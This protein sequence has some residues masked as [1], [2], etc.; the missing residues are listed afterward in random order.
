MKWCSSPTASVHLP[1]IGHSTP[2]FNW[3]GTERLVRKH[4]ASAGIP[5]YMYPSTLLICELTVA[6]EHRHSIPC[7][8]DTPTTIARFSWHAQEYTL[9]AHH[10]GPYKLGRPEVWSWT[11]STWLILIVLILHKG[12]IIFLDTIFRYYFPRSHVVSSSTSSLPSTSS[13]PPPPQPT[14]SSVSSSSLL[15]STCQP[16]PDIFS[17]VVAYLHGYEGEERERRER[18]RYLVAYDGD[19]TSD[20]TDQTTHII[21]RTGAQVSSCQINIAQC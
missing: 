6:P 4:L 1:R 7:S 12:M 13:Q 19:V 18:E 10:N 15:P 11:D 20:I 21:V 8:H 14:S 17:G 9:C 2:H 5:T 16:L 3:Y